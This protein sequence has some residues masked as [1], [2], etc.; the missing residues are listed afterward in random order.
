VKVMLFFLVF[1]KLF[2]QYFYYAAYHLYD[3]NVVPFAT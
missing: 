3:I 2:A 1:L